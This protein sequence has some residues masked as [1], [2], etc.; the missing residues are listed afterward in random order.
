MQTPERTPMRMQLA[1]VGLL[2]ILL[3]LLQDA[4]AVDLLGGSSHALLRALAVI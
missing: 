3:V 4:L 2:D 1:R